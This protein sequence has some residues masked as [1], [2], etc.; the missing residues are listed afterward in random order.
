MSSSIAARMAELS[1][2]HVPFVHATV[3]RAERPTSAHAGDDAIVLADGTIEG[4][5]GGQCAEQS[6]RT[7]AL[8]T[9]RE[10]R[11]LL[12][13]VLPGDAA[14]FP[15]SDGARVAVNPCLSGG[16]LEIFLRPSL[17]ATV[18]RVVGGTPTADAVARLAA[19][20]DLEV[21]REGDA[22]RSAAA[23]VVASHGHG[24]E[25]A[26]RAAL[27]A[28]AAYVGLV[29]SRRRGAA[30]LDAMGLTEAERA[31]VHTPAGL[32]LGAAT[33]SEIALSILAEVVQEQRSGRLAPPPDVQTVHDHHQPED[34]GGDHARFGRPHPHIG[35]D[36]ARFGREDDVQTVHDHRQGVGV[37]VDPICG[38]TVVPGDGVPRLDVGGVTYWFCATGCRDA[39]EAR[40]A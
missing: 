27:D 14:A 34:P 17:P 13:R 15:E 12:L 35:G 25:A 21:L 33:P 19:A 7:A 22:G 26:I 4:F 6:V 38:M 23:V 5:V 36:H 31:K 8:D 9:L 18:V 24:E 11:S 16:A 20:L 1:G 32:P 39:F 10:G 3:V 30:V 29:A 37:A 2:R 28:G 40:T